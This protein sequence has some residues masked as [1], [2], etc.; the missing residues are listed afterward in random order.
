MVAVMGV[1]NFGLTFSLC[2][3][4]ESQ[5]FRAAAAFESAGLVAAITGITVA[6]GTQSRV[7]YRP[8]RPILR[9]PSP[10]E[11][12]LGLVI[13]PTIGIVAGL[14][15]FAL[16]R[17]EPN[18]AHNL[19]FSTYGGLGV[20]LAVGLATA[21]TSGFGTPIELSYAPRPMQTMQDARR[22][23]LLFALIAGLG[24]G[25]PVSILFGTLSGL[26]IEIRTTLNAFQF[27]LTQG[28][29]AF[30]ATA[31]T[32]LFMT[33][34]ARYFSAS[35]L[36]AIRGAYRG[37]LLHLWRRLASSAFFELMDLLLN[38]ATNMSEVGFGARRERRSWKRE[39]TEALDDTTT[40]GSRCS[41]RRGEILEAHSYRFCR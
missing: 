40:E 9:R 13:G 6:V 14:T 39:A 34:W 1:I 22:G 8:T 36:L 5:I 27:S 21:M 24:A 3:P 37:A 23:T 12:Q 18:I 29:V 26:A 16:S 17:N 20:G 33:A 7:S 35:C 38:F 10:K 28:L 41:C 2:Y 11:F 32:C 25:I 19:E 4:L 30:I 15:F 31:S